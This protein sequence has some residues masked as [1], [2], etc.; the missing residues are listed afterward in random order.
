MTP[1]RP[2][3]SSPRC[4]AE[5]E[6][7]QE[8]QRTAEAEIAQRVVRARRR[9]GPVRRA[10]RRARGAAATR[11]T[12]PVP[13]PRRAARA[14]RDRRDVSA[15]RTRSS[16]SSQARLAEAEQR[17]R[18][19]STPSSPTPAPAP[20]S[21][22]RRA[23]SCRSRSPSSTGRASLRSTA[24]S[25]T[26]AHQRDR[27]GE[28]QA[29]RHRGERATVSELRARVER[30]R[31]HACRSATPRSWPA[32]ARPVEHQRAHRRRWSRSLAEREG[33]LHAR[34]EELSNSCD[35]DRRSAR[36]ALAEREGALFAREYDLSTTSDR[37]AETRVDTRRT[38]SR[39]LTPASR[40]SP[41]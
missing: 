31:D 32:R 18:A 17:A 35:R 13:T 1:T 11:P 3:P 6:L 30:A 12:A 15:P 29:R 25:T 41:T 2:A 16:T 28:L 4:A 22:R 26:A 7:A 10:R 27:V 9:R 21:S 38:R 5:L 40:T 39:A 33:V 19:G 34:E 36:R 37:V 20:P 24:P 23:N 8:A 14:R